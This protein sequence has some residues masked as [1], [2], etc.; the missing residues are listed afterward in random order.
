MQGV[1]GVA[2]KKAL[3]EDQHRYTVKNKSYGTTFTTA[4]EFGEV[5]NVIVNYANR[6]RVDFVVMGTD[7]SNSYRKI[8]SGSRT[9]EV[10]RK[11]NCPVLAIPE[12]ARFKVPKKILFIPDLHAPVGTS[13]LEPLLQISEKFTSE[14]STL[15]LFDQSSVNKTEPCLKQLKIQLGDYL[16]SFHLMAESRVANGLEDFLK[17]QDPDLLVLQGRHR[18]LKAIFRSWDSGKNN[19]LSGRP[20]LAIRN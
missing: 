20:L 15:I 6:H 12:A 8:F 11:A 17:E 19:A 1:L 3:I 9:R 16:R 13:P 10:L 7:G 4:T 5:S 14:I 18:F 2:A